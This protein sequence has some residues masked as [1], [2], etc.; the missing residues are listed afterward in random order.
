MSN[1]AIID[2]AIAAVGGLVAFLFGEIDGIFF[3]LIALVSL[4]YITGIISAIIKK[5]LS[6]EIGFIGILK[7][8]MIFVVVAVANIVCANVLNTD[9]ILRTAVIFFFIANEGIS[10]LENSGNIGVPIPQKLV[11]VLA[12]L[13]N[14]KNKS[15]KEKN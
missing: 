15:K 3:A 2:T 12:Q 9:G 6:S 10:I 11:D 1:R 7:K 14:D 13:K 5:K 8:T 4:D